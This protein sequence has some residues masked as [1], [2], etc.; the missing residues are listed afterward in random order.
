[1]DSNFTFVL[2]LLY[3]LTLRMCVKFVLILPLGSLLADIL[4]AKV[5]R[6]AAM[7]AGIKKRIGWHSFRHTYSTMLIAN[8]ENVKVV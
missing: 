1:M 4:L 2:P 8:D 7:R 5:S 6:P 3:L